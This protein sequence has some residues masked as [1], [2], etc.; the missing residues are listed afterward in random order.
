MNGKLQR[1]LLLVS[2]VAIA[3]LALN[4]CSGCNSGPIGKYQDA[5]HIVTLQLDPGGK[6]SISFGGLSMTATYTVEGNKITVDASGDKTVFTLNADG[7]L[8]GPP[9]GLI[10]KLEKVK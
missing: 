4:G 8:S 3:F 1:T 7:S 5:N 2:V 9:G 10:G 6:A